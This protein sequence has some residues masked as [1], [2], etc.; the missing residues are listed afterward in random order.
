MIE[1]TDTQQLGIVT[2]GEI[3]LKE[4]LEPNNITQAKLAAD[5][6]I[7]TS[8]ISDIVTGKRGITVDT[9]IRFSLYFK[10]S[11][12]FWLKAQNAYEI[13]KAEREGT[14]AIIASQIR[15]H[16]AFSDN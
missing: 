11:I 9:A 1:H 12:E 3:L 6:D 15:Y 7:P 16:K 4:F 5:L 13:E 14:C 10:T 2:P 8:R